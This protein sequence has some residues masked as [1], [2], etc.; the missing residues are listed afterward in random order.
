[1]LDQA[2]RFS[3]RLKREAGDSTVAQVKLAFDLALNRP[4]SAKELDQA[5]TFIQSTPTGLVDFAQTVFN[6]NEFA[7]AP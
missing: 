3:E 2:K 5:V 4:P 1:V 7:Y 6:L